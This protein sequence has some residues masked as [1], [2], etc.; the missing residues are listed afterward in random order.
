MA[1]R[2]EPGR[3]C[4]SATAGWR[5]SVAT[6]AGIA[7]SAGTCVTARTRA[8][9]DSI[10]ESQ[11]RQVRKLWCSV[12]WA[13][14]WNFVAPTWPRRAKCS[15]W[16]GCACRGA[17]GRSVPG[18]PSECSPPSSSVPRRL[19][20]VLHWCGRGRGGG[21]APVGLGMSPHW[22]CRRRCDA[23][24]FDGLPQAI[25]TIWFKIT[26]TSANRSAG[27]RFIGRRRLPV[28]TTAPRRACRSPGF[29]RRAC[30]GRIA[31]G[32]PPG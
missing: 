7:G 4:G 27:R 13:P 32:A 2:G 8:C 23:A 11:V 10:R 20:G 24:C 9:G 1:A 12:R 19:A 29:R 5:C 17:S 25:R 21:S 3:R 18:S 30:R 26:P 14:S 31:P 28:A 16:R 6:T 22:R 15:V